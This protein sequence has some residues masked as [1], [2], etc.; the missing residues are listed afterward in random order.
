MPKRLTIAFSDD[1]VAKTAWSKEGG[2]SMFSRMGCGLKS[3]YKD[4]E[5]YY[6]IFLY[7]FLIYRSRRRDAFKFRLRRAAT[8]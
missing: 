4:V 7:S 3:W 8:V 6:R 5:Y 1:F 2:A